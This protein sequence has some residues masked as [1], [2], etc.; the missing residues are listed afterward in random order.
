MATIRMWFRKDT[1]T[2]RRNMCKLSIARNDNNDKH[3][4]HIVSQWASNHAH[5]FYVA[6]RGSEQWYNNTN[7]A[8]SKKLRYDKETQ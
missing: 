7:I 3:V 2:S 6:L 8:R 4:F 1:S 5:I